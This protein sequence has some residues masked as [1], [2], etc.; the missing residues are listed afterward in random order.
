MKPVPQ[1]VTVIPN[2]GVNH[3][4]S[5]DTQPSQ[6]GEQP[7]QG[8]VPPSQASVA[9]QEGSQVVM[10][11]TQ[12]PVKLP[13]LETF[14]KLIDTVEEQVNQNGPKCYSG[15]DVPEYRDEALEEGSEVEDKVI[16][17]VPE[18]RDEGNLYKRPRNTVEEEVNQKDPK[19]YSCDPCGL[20]VWSSS[21]LDEH[22]SEEHGVRGKASTETL[23]CDHCGTRAKWGSISEWHMKS[24][25]V[26]FRSYK[27]EACE[28][29]L[30]RNGNMSDQPERVHESDRGGATCNKVETLTGNG[31]L[32]NGLNSEAG[33]VAGSC[34]D[35]G[36][37]SV[38]RELLRE[39][40]MIQVRVVQWRLPMLSLEKKTTLLGNFM[41]LS[42]DLKL[43]MKSR[44]K[45]VLRN[46]RKEIQML[47][48]R[49]WWEVKKLKIEAGIDR[50]EGHD[51]T[52]ELE[53]NLVSR[54][55]EIR[56]SDTVEEEASLD[57][58]EVN[59][60]KVAV[61]NV[62]VG[63]GRLEGCEACENRAATVTIMRCHMR[64]IHEWGDEFCELEVSLL[65]RKFRGFFCGHC[66]IPAKREGL[67][68]WHTGSVHGNTVEVVCQHCG[69]VKLVRTNTEGL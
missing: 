64:K 31:N 51:D 1:P 10:F 18:E 59:D 42:W 9:G 16:T 49:N 24:I 34:L 20:I 29:D 57:N 32:I 68:E 23:S 40:V 33:L 3:F 39:T 36:R 2:P 30:R 61:D 13:G 56:A 37:G 26:D 66:G 65:C 44:I 7:V 27:C 67:K 22:K 38:E 54:L 17:E 35:W 63:A 53:A 6:G 25:H 11:G 69:E 55:I 43:V 46:I 14:S 19:C 5:Q 60:A 4:A 47:L 45:M 50:A 21:H 48:A 15:K 52:E 62:K 8:Q 41:L 28:E 12:P 58:F